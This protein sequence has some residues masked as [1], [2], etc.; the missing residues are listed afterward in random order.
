MNVGAVASA[1]GPSVNRRIAVLVGI[2]FFFQLI[3]FLIGSS[4]IERYLD[5]DA[6]RATLVVGV[7]LE[8]C[9]GLA[10]GLLMYQVLKFRLHRIFVAPSRRAA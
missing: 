3:T 7:A 4:L 10:V 5:G 9:A 6:D 8:M 2:L 1:R